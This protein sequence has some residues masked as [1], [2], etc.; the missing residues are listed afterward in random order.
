MRLRLADIHGPDVPDSSQSGGVYLNE[1]LTRFDAV[2]RARHLAGSPDP[3]GPAPGSDRL[4]A[5]VNAD[6]DS[7]ALP[8]NAGIAELVLALAETGRVRLPDGAADMDRNGLD[9][10][11]FRAWL[12][13]VLTFL[14][15]RARERIRR[16]PD[17]RTAI[18]QGRLDKARD[19]KQE[20]AR[21]GREIATV[22]ALQFGDLGWLVTRYEGWYVFF[23]VESRRQAKRLVKQLEGLRNA[24]AHGQELVAGEWKTLVAVARSVV[25]IK[26]AEREGEGEGPAG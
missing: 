25:A 18:S 7:P 19:L 16:D 1:S 12:F 10:L 14:E 13:G 2:F 22:D 3:R 17:W 26:A 5:P 23:G 9:S 6:A 24:L 11:V 4:A 15:A 21:R 20:R 8:A